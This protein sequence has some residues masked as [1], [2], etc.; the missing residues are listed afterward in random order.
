MITRNLIFSLSIRVD[1]YTTYNKKSDNQI[2]NWERHLNKHF[3]K[4]DSETASTHLK[5][6]Q[7]HQ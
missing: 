3:I 2:Q 1:F 7:P 6:P 5:D 4:E